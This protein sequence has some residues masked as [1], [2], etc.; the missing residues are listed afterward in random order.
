MGL[1]K[2]K[3]RLK[4]AFKVTALLDTSLEINIITRKVME[5]ASLPMQRGSKLGL[6]SHTGH[7]CLFPDLCKGVKIAIKGLKTR[8]PIFM[9]KQGDYDLVLGQLF[10]NLVKFSQKYKPNGIFGTITHLYTE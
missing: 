1:S 9:F 3:I 5:D 7:I 2:A 10:L 6:I 8:Y 4:N